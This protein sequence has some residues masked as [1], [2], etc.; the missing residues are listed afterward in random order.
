M[1]LNV[2]F[3]TSLP[4][5]MAKHSPGEELAAYLRAKFES[6]G[7]T[8]S[9]I[10]NYEDFAWALDTEQDGK[11]LFILL[12]HTQDPDDPWLLQINE[13]KTRFIDIFRGDVALKQRELLAA[14]IHSVLVADKMIDCLRWY[15]GDFANG[16]PS[17]TPNP[18]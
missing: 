2:T 15:E 12:G 3:K 18:A 1:R 17:A 6:G 14:R 9:A 13:Y 5:D 16:N 11:K 8:I 10:D 7:I 4:V